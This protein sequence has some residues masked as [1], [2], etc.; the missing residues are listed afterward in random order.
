VRVVATFGV[1]AL[2]ATACLYV[3]SL[4]GVHVPTSALLAAAAPALVTTAVAYIALSQSAAAA[5]VA[6]LRWWMPVVWATLAAND[7]VVWRLADRAT[8]GGHVERVAGRTVLVAH[9]QVLRAL[10]TAGVR[11]IDLWEVRALGAHLL[12]ML[13]LSSLGLLA[14]LAPTK[15]AEL[16]PPA[17]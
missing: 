11:A 6:G 2:A 5:A 7:A 1:L 13:A 14:L 17:P 16:R 3:A 10:D 9:G 15:E 4:A 12:V 8:G